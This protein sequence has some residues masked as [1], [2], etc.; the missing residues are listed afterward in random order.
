MGPSSELSCEAGSFSRCLTPHRFLQSEVLRL[1]FP[2]LEPWVARFVS[3]PSSPSR[4]ICTRMRDRPIC[5]PLPCRES[6]P[7]RLPVSAPPTSL[8][9]CFFFISL[10]VGLPYRLVFCQFWLF[11]V[12]KLFLSFF[13]LCEE[14]QCVYLCL[15]L[16]QKFVW[17]V[18]LS[19]QLPCIF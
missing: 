3:L 8:G 17:V 1:Y 7:P 10:V 19:T 13:W 18:F 6:S 9:E 16:G 14:A 15:H 12:F 5:Q 4:F 2:T 11:F